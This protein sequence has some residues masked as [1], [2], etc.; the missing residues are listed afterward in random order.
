MDGKPADISDGELREL[1]LNPDV[2][3]DLARESGVLDDMLAY[4][5]G[6]IADGFLLTHLQEIDPA[7]LEN[8]NGTITDVDDLLATGTN[9]RDD[10][11]APGTVAML[12]G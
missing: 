10:G 2:Y 6:Q 12:F 8:G 9:T 7:R 11:L 5:E 4:V 1:L 3:G